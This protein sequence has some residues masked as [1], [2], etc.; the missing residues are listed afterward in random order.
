[1][2]SQVHQTRDLFFSP[3]TEPDVIRNLIV[4]EIT[5]SS[6][7]LIWDEPIVNKHFFKIQWTGDQ[8]NGHSSTSNTSYHIT[9]LTAGVSYTFCITAVPADNSTGE[10]VCNSKYTS[11]WHF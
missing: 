4:S 2:N 1:M 6:M 9:G 10:T 3:H 11:M 5:T 8:T 7:F